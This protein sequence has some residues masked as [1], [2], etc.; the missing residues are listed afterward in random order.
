MGE[1]SFQS[2]TAEA[3]QAQAPRTV[4]APAIAVH[5][6]TGLGV[7]LPVPSAT[8]GFGDV[9]ADAHGFEVHERLI[10]VIALV[11]YHLVDAVAIGSHR[12]DLLGRFNQRLDAGGLGYFP[13]KK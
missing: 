4:N 12:L 3:Q 1:G 5:G 9:T 13:V 2:L 10:A 11:A 6:V 7:L 8:I